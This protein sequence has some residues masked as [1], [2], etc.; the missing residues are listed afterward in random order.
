MNLVTVDVWLL[1][2]VPI[3]RT[4]HSNLGWQNILLL[5]KYMMAIQP[6]VTKEHEKHTQK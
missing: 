4:K 1:E 2:Q 3:V 5:S 6:L